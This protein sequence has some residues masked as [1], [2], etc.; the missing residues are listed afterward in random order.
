MNEK[1]VYSNKYK[2]YKF[3][4]N[5]DLALIHENSQLLGNPKDKVC[6]CC[7]KKEVKRLGFFDKILK[8]EYKCLDLLNLITLM[9]IYTSILIIE[10]INFCFFNFVFFI[11]YDNENNIYII[12]IIY[13]VIQIILIIIIITIGVEKYFNY[14]NLLYFDN[15]PNLPVYESEFS[16]IMKQINKNEFTNKYDNTNILKILEIYDNK[17]LSLQW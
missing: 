13:L 7:N 9:N 11:N 4:P 8:H 16:L 3:P 14:N 1:L 15:L 6:L 5:T 2:P 17:M 12:E 10:I